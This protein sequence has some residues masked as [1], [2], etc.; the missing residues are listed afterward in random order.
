MNLPALKPGRIRWLFAIALAGIAIALVAIPLSAIAVEEIEEGNDTSAIA[1]D[2]NSLKSEQPGRPKVSVAPVG[3]FDA[4][5][6]NQ[7][8]RG[9]IRARRESSLAIRRA[10]KLAKVLVHEGDQVHKGDMLALLETTDLDVR[11]KL[12]EAEL[13]AASAAATEAI[14]GPRYQTLKSAAARVRQLQVQWDS[15]KARFERQKRLSG[16]NAGSEQELDDTKYAAAELKA[17]LDASTAELEE[18]NEGTRTEQLDAAKANRTAALAAREQVDVDRR[19]SQIVAPY[20]GVIAERFVDEGEMLSA[21]IPVVRILEVDPLEA[22]FG[23]PVDTASNWKIGDRFEV[24]VGNQT[25]SAK[26]ARMQPQVDP[27][28]RTRAVQL[29][30]IPSNGVSAIG[31][32]TV[33]Q[34]ASLLVPVSQSDAT[35]GRGNQFWLPT[36]ALV[37]GSRGLWSVYVAVSASQASGEHGR[38]A[39]SSERNDGSMIERR[40]VRVVRADNQV[41]LVEGMIGEGELL[42]IDGAHRI[43]PGV[44][45]EAAMALSVD[46]STVSEV[47]APHDSPE[48]LNR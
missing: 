41:S 34:T 37:R 45:V 43:G 16:R 44:A 8:Y 39:T 28:T 35:S 46:P 40:D 25:L 12:A 19:D 2:G 23:V 13:A 18:L 27:L 31:Q 30:L 7:S 38:I 47:P 4:P 22:H 11:Q 48:K 24:V 3:S 32:A 14:A 6:M 15:A 9:V 29:E 5:P 1:S 36:A 20:D 26:I 42:V 10:G 33:G 17:R 21:G